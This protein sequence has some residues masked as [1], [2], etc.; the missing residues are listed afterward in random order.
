MCLAVIALMASNVYVGWLFWDARQ[1][2]R[3]LLSRMFS[4]GQ[5]TAEA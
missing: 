5:Q 1:R 3:G 4:M 2:Y